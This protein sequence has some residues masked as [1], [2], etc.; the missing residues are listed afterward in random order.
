[1][2]Q[3][4]KS[5]AATARKGSANQPTHDELREKLARDLSAVMKNPALPTHIYSTL[6][7]ELAALYSWTDYNDAEVILHGLIAW[8]AEE[9]NR[10]RGAR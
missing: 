7:E 2:S 4:S 3:S 9:A 5:K 1:M 10:K 8:D 6:T